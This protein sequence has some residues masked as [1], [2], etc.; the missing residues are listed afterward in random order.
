M[1][2]EALLAHKDLHISK[3]WLSFVELKKLDLRFNDNGTFKCLYTM[4]KYVQLSPL[5]VELENIRGLKFL[6]IIESSCL[7]LHFLFDMKNGPR[8][9]PLV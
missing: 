2:D 6:N 9:F 1:K 4:T 7:N 3:K 5:N 8:W